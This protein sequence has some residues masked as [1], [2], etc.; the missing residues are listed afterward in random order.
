[1]RFLSDLQPRADDK[2][3]TEFPLRE[4]LKIY[5]KSWKGL[6][7]TSA[8]SVAI[9][10][11]GMLAVAIAS[12]FITTT[13]LVATGSAILTFFATLITDHPISVFVFVAFVVA[14]IAVRV[15][16]AH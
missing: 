1:M 12:M 3:I 4:S 14:L 11:V 7:S 10:G 6:V 15:R 8:M 9:A 16:T 2:L 5:A 13:A